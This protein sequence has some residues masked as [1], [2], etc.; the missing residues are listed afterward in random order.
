MAGW[1]TKLLA[2]Q[3]TIGDLIEASL[4]SDVTTWEAG[5]TSPF[6]WTYSHEPNG[7]QLS[8]YADGINEFVSFNGCSLTYREERRIRKALFAMARRE[9]DARRRRA[10]MRLAA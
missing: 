3:V 4:T 10:M 6:T 5:R 1:L 7:W 9:R 8:L 2:K